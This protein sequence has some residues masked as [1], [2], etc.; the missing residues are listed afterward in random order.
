VLCALRGVKLGECGGLRYRPGL[1][2][3]ACV[4]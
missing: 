3:V 1:Q 2:E 4:R